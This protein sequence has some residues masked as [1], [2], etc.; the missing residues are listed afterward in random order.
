MNILIPTKNHTA[1]A[2][3]TLL[4][5]E[6]KGSKMFSGMQTCM[7]QGFRAQ[8]PQAYDLILQ[9]L[10]LISEVYPHGADYLQVF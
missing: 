2:M 8:F 4:P 3:L 9:S 5:Q 1:T 6:R 10:R 7:T